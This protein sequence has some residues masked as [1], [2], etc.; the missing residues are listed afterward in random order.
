MKKIKF[1]FVVHFQ[2]RTS[3]SE[4]HF[5]VSYT[6]KAFNVFAALRLAE[7]I[8]HLDFNNPCVDGFIV[9]YDNG[10]KNIS[11]KI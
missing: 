11:N 2:I 6:V 4:T 8:L 3:S 7:N 9:N 10:L 1:T 5:N